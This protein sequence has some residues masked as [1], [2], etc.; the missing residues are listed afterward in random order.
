MSCWVSC[1]AVRRA[2]QY[3][4]HGSRGKAFTVTAY[5]VV[6]NFNVVRVGRVPAVSDG[7]E[8]ELSLVLARVM[9]WQNASVAWERGL[10]L[11]VAHRSPALDRREV[12][13]A[14]QELDG[15]CIIAQLP[16][17]SDNRPAQRNV[18]IPWLHAHDTEGAVAVSVAEEESEWA[19]PEDA[20]QELA[21]YDSD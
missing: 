6:A 17:N 19:A 13:I 7:G 4:D 12:Y 5:G 20:E 14:P 2:A 8:R 15:V 11:H 16:V 3:D 10:G 21:V 1:R 18:L 9:W